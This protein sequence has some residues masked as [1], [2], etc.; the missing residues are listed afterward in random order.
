MLDNSKIPAKENNA[1]TILITV[2]RGQTNIS[3]QKHNVIFEVEIALKTT[4]DVASA[5]FQR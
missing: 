3:Q 2:R 1:I 4:S 5:C